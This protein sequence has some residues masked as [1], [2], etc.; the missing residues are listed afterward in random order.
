MMV[1]APDSGR[2]ARLTGAI[3]FLIRLNLT[4]SSH[5]PLSADDKLGP[6]KIISAIGKGGTG[7]VWRGRDPWLGQDIAM[8]GLGTTVP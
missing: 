1:P 4:E 6:Y 3:P 5:M 2:N 7:G 8:K